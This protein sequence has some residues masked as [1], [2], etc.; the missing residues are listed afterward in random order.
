MVQIYKFHC[1]MQRIWIR[2]RLW[3][4]LSTICQLYHGGYF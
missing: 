1:C 4:I 2:T 3:Y